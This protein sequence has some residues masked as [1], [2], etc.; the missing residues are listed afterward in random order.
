MMAATVV[1]VVVEHS[2]AF[3]EILGVM[4]ESDCP[5]VLQVRGTDTTVYRGQSTP[6]WVLYRAAVTGHGERHSGGG[7]H[8]LDPHPW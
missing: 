5:S 4:L 6:R 8:T 3:Y 1:R 2:P 7:R